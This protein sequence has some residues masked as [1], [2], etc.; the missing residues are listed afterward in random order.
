M[1]TAG[2]DGYLKVRTVPGVAMHE[3]VN[4]LLFSAL[5]VW[6]LRKYTSLQSYRL[7]HPAVSVDISDRGL[8]GVGTGRSIQVLRN[9][10]TQCKDVT[11]LNHSIRTPNPSLS[12]GGGALASKKSLLSSV[13]VH[14]VCFRPLED[15]LGVG[16]SHGISSFIVPGAGEPNFDSFENNPFTTLRQ[17]REAE[18]QSLLNKL[19]HET[20][21]LG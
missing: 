16:H 3:P 14:S 6:D 7:D 11:Y 10:F 8:I 5:Q 2:L 18:V 12:S 4:A 1:V 15:V 20:I 17:R 13:K 9:A 21:A 19:S